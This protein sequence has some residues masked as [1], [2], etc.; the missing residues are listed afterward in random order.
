MPPKNELTRL[1]ESV[2]TMANDLRRRADRLGR[3]DISRRITAEAER[4]SE[5]RS[6]VVFV[7]PRAAGKSSLVASLVGRSDLPLTT[8]T[9]VPVLVR[10]SLTERAL[11]VDADGRTAERTVVGLTIDPTRTQYVELHVDA[12]RM[13][14]GVTLVDTPGAGSVADPHGN[15]AYLASRRADQIIVVVDLTA[16]IARSDLELVQRCVDRFASVILVGTHIER[17]RGWQSVLQDSTDAI[18]RV[19]PHLDIVSIGVSPVLADLAFGPDVDD[20]E[21][22][23]LLD[24]S[25]VSALQ[26]EM[27]QLVDQRRRRRL[28]NFSTLLDSCAT[29]LARDGRVVIL[30]SVEQT[31]DDVS[32]LA[33][34]RQELARVRDDRS[35]WFAAL[36]DA[37]TSAREET[38]IDLHRIVSTLN[39]QFESRIEAFTGNADGLIDEFEIDAATAASTLAARIADRVGGIIETMVA[40]TEASDLGVRPDI[41][42]IA[43]QL[44]AAAAES[45]EVQARRAKTDSSLKLRATGGLV[46]VATS[47]TM[48]M[49]AMAGSGGAAALMRVGAFGAAT[50]FSGVS[51]AVAVAGRRRQRTRQQI[52]NT[53]RA[54]TDAIRTNQQ[55]VLKR[56]FLVVQRSIE[57][58]VKELVRERIAVLE[59]ELSE[60]QTTARADASERRRRAATL[61]DELRNVAALQEQANALSSQLRGQVGP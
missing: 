48:M 40:I 37:V 6:S 43:H 59:R 15:Q 5:A 3:T 14:D 45:S 11:V 12:P 13:I 34:L 52:R 29:E 47:S 55:T 44:E 18:L 50:L 27:A 41:D 36:G 9:A 20:A 10:S 8:A 42:E 58:S 26:T 7:G 19:A 38:S 60:L 21:A 25:G 39:E 35:S 17:I 4:W 57:A 56:Y 22:L 61:E 46:G 32:R 49:T 2:S 23:E 1:G 16:P 28:S 24:D 31:D 30:A 51:A 54:R 53:V 33:E